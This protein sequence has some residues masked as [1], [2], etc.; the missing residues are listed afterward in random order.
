MT[1][2][3]NSCLADSEKNLRADA[4][5]NRNQI[6]QAAYKI[7]AEKGLSVPISEIAREAEVGIGTI[8]R[9]FETKEA[10]F[11][12]VN[13]NYKQKL[14]EE[15]K[16]LINHTDP[17]KAFFDFLFRVMEVSLTNKAVRDAFRIG[18]FRVREASSGVLLDFQSACTELLTRA[19]QAKAVRDD[20][21]IMDLFSLMSGLLMVI[22]DSEGVSNRN[23]FNKLLSIICDGLRY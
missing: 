6:L 9:H 15:A 11:D 7:F 1:N 12:A 20:I 14:T 23:K 2:K 19:Q 4:K 3:I 22:D 10:L 16:S 5:E 8:Y 13:I 21:D 17:G 18:T